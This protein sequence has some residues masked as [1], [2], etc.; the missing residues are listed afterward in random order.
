MFAWR[1]SWSSTGEVFLN[2]LHCHYCN[3]ISLSSIDGMLA[4]VVICKYSLQSIRRR[5]SLSICLDIMNHFIKKIS[6]R[7]CLYNC[8]NN[9]VKGY[10]YR[11]KK[12]KSFIHVEVMVFSD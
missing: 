8:G 6:S 1:L 5:N 10:H 7:R 4:K 3:I 9:H 12:H 2:M 11:L